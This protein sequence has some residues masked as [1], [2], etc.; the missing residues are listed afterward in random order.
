MNQLLGFQSISNCLSLDASV[1]DNVEYPSTDFIVKMS[2]QLSTASRIFLGIGANLAPEGY[3]DP[4]AG[5]L[6]AIDSLAGEGILMLAISPWY[7]AAPVPASDQPWYQNAVVEVETGLTPE[8]LM[9]V[10]HDCELRFGRVRIRRNEPR[11]LDIDL[12]D[13]RGLVRDAPP[14]LPHPRMHQRGFVLRP[15]ADLAPEWIHPATGAPIS[16][17]IDGLDPSE[18]IERD[19][20]NCD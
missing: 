20:S 6:A 12:I 2:L 10:L 17:L 18:E 5:C 4:R 11:V 3:P 9:D 13:F 7:R 16:E 19:D 14:V 8:R 15:L 1:V